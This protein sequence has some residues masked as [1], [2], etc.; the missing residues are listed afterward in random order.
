[1]KLGTTYV[2]RKVSLGDNSVKHKNG[3]FLNPT[4]QSQ[5]V[6]RKTKDYHEDMGL[7]AFVSFSKDENGEI[8]GEPPEVYAGHGYIEC[9]FDEVKWDYFFEVNFN[10]LFEQADPVNFP[11]KD[12]K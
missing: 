8:L 12:N 2:V 3:L 1:M 11:P 9:D 7:V 5:V 4:K 6:L 10:S